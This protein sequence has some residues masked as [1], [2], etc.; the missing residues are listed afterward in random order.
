MGDRNGLTEKIE[1]QQMDSE[2]MIC[3]KIDEQV[4]SVNL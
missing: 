1:E 2:K 3:Y 4:I